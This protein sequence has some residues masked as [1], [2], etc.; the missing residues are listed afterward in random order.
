MILATQL[1]KSRLR[2][3][4]RPPSPSWPYLEP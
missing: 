2:S 1:Y 4:Q 3:K